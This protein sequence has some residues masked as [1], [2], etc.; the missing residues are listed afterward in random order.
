VTIRTNEG[1][2]Q[3]SQ[4]FKQNEAER[5]VVE[6]DEVYEAGSKITTKP[7]FL[8]EFMTSDHSVTQRTVIS[9]V[10]APGLLGFFYRKLGKS[11]IGNALLASYKTYFKQQHP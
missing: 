10:E 1:L 4:I 7:H 11:N 2:M 3:R 5:I 8:D 9:G 6:F